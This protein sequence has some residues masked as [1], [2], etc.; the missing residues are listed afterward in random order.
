MG[1]LVLDASIAMTWC[2][3][4][5]HS[6]F[7]YRVLDSLAHRQAVVPSL[8]A[9]EVANALVVGERRQR[10]AAS[11]VARFWELLNA[12]SIETD[13]QTARR[14]L[15]ETLHL[16]RTY[17]L[18]AYDAAYLELA[19]REGFVLATLDGRLKNAA[20]KAGGKIFA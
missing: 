7:A 2:Y 8:W 6:D 13:T 16:A 9:M 18:S 11:D 4:D 3:P 1:P 5:E 17:G 10:L 12:L 15:S 20:K 19:M 14:A